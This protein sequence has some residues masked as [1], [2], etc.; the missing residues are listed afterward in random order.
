MQRYS[1]FLGRK[2]RYCENDY[3]TRRKLQFQFDPYQI[4]NGIF[5]RAR[6]KKFTILLETQRP[7]IAKAVR[8]KNG[9]GGINLPEF[10]L[11]YKATVIKTVILTQH[12]NIDQWNKIEIPEINPCTYV[13]LIFDKG[14]KNIQWGKDS[15]FN[16]SFWEN[17]TATYKRMKLEHFLTLYTKRN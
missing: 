16:K 6:T 14:G 11:Y 1:M 9:A 7:W 2:N 13:Y 8:K 15:L 3:T 4:A 12:R 17:W 5:H 10:R